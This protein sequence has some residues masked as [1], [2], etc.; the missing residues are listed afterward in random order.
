MPTPNCE[1]HFPNSLQASIDNTQECSH[2][3]RTDLKTKGL[4]ET[5]EFLRG[6]IIQEAQILGKGGY[7][8][9][10]LWNLSQGCAAGIFTVLSDWRI[11]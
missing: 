5:A 1:I 11:C 8:K 4:C 7:R 9:V 6:L 3:L 10:I 2:K